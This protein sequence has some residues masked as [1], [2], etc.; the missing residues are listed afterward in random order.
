MTDD[1]PAVAYVTRKWPPAMGGMETYSQRLTERLAPRCDLTVI[2]LPGR[3][4]GSAPGALALIL[5]GIGSFLRLLLGRSFDVV[6]LGDMAIWPLGLAAR[7]RNRR[8]RIVISAHGTD[9]S[10]GQRPG[11]AARLYR[12]YLRLA[13]RLLPSMTVISNSHATRAL[14]E[15]YGF[16]RGPVVALGTDMPPQEA[17]SDRGM[18]LFSGRLVRRKGCLWFARNVLPRLPAHLRLAVAGTV[19]DAAEAEALGLER[20]EPLGRLDAP[21]LAR[22]YASALVTVVP[23]I[24]PEPSGF[25]GFGLVA[26][27]AASAGGVVVAARLHGLTDAVVDGKT[28]F[29]LPSEDAA[30]WAE[31]IIE[32]AGWSDAER[33]EFT[34]TAKRIAGE[35]YSWDRVADETLAA[36]RARPRPC[37]PDTTARRQ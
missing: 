14:T 8:T 23:N 1:R 5:F 10:F 3:A 6:H 21:A 32:I 18:I 34:G 24:D 9:V 37:A 35:T 19:W 25:E 26:A 31:K 7:L 15:R 16:R 20:V 2:A 33:A 12:A 36:Y 11:I 29:L 30:A 17:K 28:G 13:P 22:T 27:E 4:D